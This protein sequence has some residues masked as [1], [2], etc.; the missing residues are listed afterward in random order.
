[1]PEIIV[2]PLPFEKAIAFFRDKVVLTPDKYNSL[3]AEARSKAFSVSGVS[4]MNVLE[5]LFTETERGLSEGTS[6]GDFKKGVKGIMEKRGW[7]G[8]APYRLDTIFRNNIQTAYQAGHYQ[9]QMETAEDL[10]YWEYVAVMD[11]RTRP[12]HRAMNGKVF[13]YD[14]P[15]WKSSY[16]PNGFNCRCT[17]RALTE[18]Q[19]KREKLTVGENGP[20]IAEKG[21]DVNPAEV[22]GKRLPAEQFKKLQSDPERWTPLIKKGFENYG[23]KSARDFK[24]YRSSGVELWPR[25]NKAVEMYKVNMMGKVFKDAVKEPLIMNEELI[26]HIKLDGREQYLPLIEDIVTKPQEIWLQAE[27][28]K[29][30]GKVVLRKRYIDIIEVEKGRRLIFVADACKGQWMGYTFYPVERYSTLDNI[31]S[32]VLLYE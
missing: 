14:D 13:K 29:L 24:D 27:K 26:K 1:M 5:D 20:G 23:L 6:F 18:G 16:P 28:E 8:A 21:W 11:P 22:M 15:F 2:K 17:V 25:G 30:T 3:T 12:A 31:R 7:E 32:G 19:V 4:K 10:P 9:Q